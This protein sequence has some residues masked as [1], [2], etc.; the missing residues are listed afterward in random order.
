MKFS[1]LVLAGAIAATAVVTGS[2]VAAQS[3][4]EEAVDSVVTAVDTY[5]KS[6]EASILGICLHLL[7]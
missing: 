7:F 1:K 2:H 3:L 6:R 4:S 5:R